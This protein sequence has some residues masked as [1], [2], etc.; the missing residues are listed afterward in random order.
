MHNYMHTNKYVLPNGISLPLTWRDQRLF[1]NGLKHNFWTFLFK[2][3]LFINN[4]ETYKLSSAVWA[5]HQFSHTTSPLSLTDTYTSS[6]FT[7]KN[8]HQERLKHFTL[9]SLNTY[10]FLHP[11]QRAIFTLYLHQT[12]TCYTDMSSMLSMEYLLQCV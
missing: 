10:L 3:V 9:H 12:L 8:S 1:G 2:G 11:S 6:H 5:C 7:D 4:Q